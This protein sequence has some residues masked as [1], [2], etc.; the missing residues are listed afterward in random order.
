M[1]SVLG[2]FPL[3]LFTTLGAFGAG[4]FVA[5]AIAFF[6]ENYSDEEYKSIDKKTLVPLIILIVGFICV[7]FHVTAPLKAFGVFEGIGRSPLSNEVVFG[8]IFVVVAL[9]YTIM[10]CAHKLGGASG[11]HGESDA[12]GASDARGANGAG[13]EGSASGAGSAGGARKGFAAIVAILAVGFAV[14]MGLAYMVNTI[15]SWC[16]AGTVCQMLGFMLVGTSLGFVVLP[17]KEKVSKTLKILVIVGLVLAIIGLVVQ[18]VIASGMASGLAGSGSVYV[19]AAAPYMVAAAVLAIIAAIL[20]FAKT[21]KA[22]G[23]VTINAVVC[24]LFLV[25]VLFARLA[26]YVMQVSIGI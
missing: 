11:A 15:P 26:F 6:S 22:A 5:L 3:A 7:A 23:T 20:C 1:E 14:M 21:G 16:N 4:G 2:H 24:V 8:G 10:A 25:A 9:I 19:A 12:E 13:N 18:C 17:A